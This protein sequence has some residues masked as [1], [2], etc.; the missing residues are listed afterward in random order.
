MSKEQA[1]KIVADLIAKHGATK[2]AEALGITRQYA[3]MIKYGKRKPGPALLEK[4]GFREIR[5]IIQVD[6]LIHNV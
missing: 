3:Y 2:T 6:E 1:A 5:Q 4:L